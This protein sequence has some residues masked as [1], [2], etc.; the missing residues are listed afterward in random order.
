MTRS[1]SFRLLQASHPE[2]ADAIATSSVAAPPPARVDLDQLKTLMLP[3]NSPAAARALTRLII[4]LER[5]SPTSAAIAGSMQATATAQNAPVVILTMPELEVP[6]T[7]EDPKISESSGHH[8]FVVW[9][10]R[11]EGSC[12]YVFKTRTDA[13][14]WRSGAGLERFPIRLVST[15]TPFKWRT[16]TGSVS[17]IELADRLFE[18]Y[19][20]EEKM[21][22]GSSAQRAFLDPEK[23]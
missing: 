15:E 19:T 23:R 20:D 1:I 11:P 4:N 9:R 7:V 12:E 6:P 2:L 18:I 3:S 5:P 8:G 13:E 10:S 22:S 17:G 14:K 16:S 21:K